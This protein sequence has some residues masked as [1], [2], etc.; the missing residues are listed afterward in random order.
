MKGVRPLWRWTAAGRRD[1]RPYPRGSTLRGTIGADSGDPHP[2]VEPPHCATFEVEVR[3]RLT[4]RVFLAPIS[5]SAVGR[6][7]AATEFRLLALVGGSERWAA[8]AQT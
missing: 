7:R 2:W 6:D 8:M 5:V 4:G 1:D 3:W